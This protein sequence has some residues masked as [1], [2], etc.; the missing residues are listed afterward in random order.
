MT[1]GE[2]LLTHN[3]R[4]APDT[5]DEMAGAELFCVMAVNTWKSST[6]AQSPEKSRSEPV[7]HA[8][9]LSTLSNASS[10]PHSCTATVS[11]A[12]TGCTCWNGSC[13]LRL[14]AYTL[15]ASPSSAR[16]EKP[17]PG[18]LYSANRC[19]SSVALVEVMRTL[20][21]SGQPPTTLP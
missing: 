10:P 19:P 6:H 11:V 17:C 12:S 2:E 15:F 5:F 20:T 16:L 14:S 21:I 4:D 18:R 1:T 13:A 9:R 3:D 7:E 8:Q